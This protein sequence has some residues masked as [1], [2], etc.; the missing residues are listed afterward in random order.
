MRW[1]LGETRAFKGVLSA[2]EVYCAWKSARSTA[3]VL[4]KA[5][6]KHVKACIDPNFNV[7]ANLYKGQL[8]KLRNGPK[9]LI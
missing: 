2:R 9:N 5:G 4:L 3:L 7:S 8:S 6:C 1:V